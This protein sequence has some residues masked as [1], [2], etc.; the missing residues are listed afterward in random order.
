MMI[1]GKTASEG[2]AVGKAIRLEKETI[3][4]EKQG[5]DSIE[6]CLKAF[7]EALE[8]SREEIKT[9]Q[10]QAEDRLGSEQ[11]EIFGAHLE[12][13]DDPEIRKQVEAM[14]END[15]VT[16]AYAYQTITDQYIQMFEQMEDE[17]FRGRAADIKDIQ[18]RVLA[19]LL[20]KE[21][22]DLSLLEEDTIVVAKDLTPSDTAGLDL[23]K[24]KGF[25]TES[26]GRTSHTAIIA[27]ALGLPAIVGANGALEAIEDNQ[28][29]FLNASDNE[30]VVDPGKKTL[31]RARSLGRE[32]EKERERLKAYADR[33]TKTMNGKGIPLYANIGSDKELD[34]VLENGAEGVGLFRTEFLFMDQPAMPD[35]ERQI[36]AY[37]RVFEKLSPVIVRTLDIGGDKDLPYLEQPKEANPF[38]GRRAIRLT[39]E[40]ESLFQTQ[41]RALLRAARNQRD[42]RIMF[43]MVATEKELDAALEALERARRSLD[44]EGYE[45]QTNIKVGIMIEIPAAALNARRL[46]EKVH[47]FSIGTNDL[48]QYLFAADRMNESV[49]YLYQPLDTTLLRLIKHV[50]DEAHAEQTEVGV[51][52]EIAGDLDAALL[53]A[54]IGVDELSMS[55][56]SI[57]RIREALARI[58]STDLERLSDAVL[59]EHSPQTAKEIVQAFRRKHLEG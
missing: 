27:R 29:V 28:R 26:G 13:L 6:A 30:I 40:E 50:V 17:Y 58:D 55:P 42:V 47:F 53:L 2:Y 21:V 52:G 49:A 37:E 54:G 11:A 4:A 20:G 44:E 12:M 22:K 7:R 8:K 19:H 14:I 15:Q 25:I 16:A 46:A 18:Q 56:A 9:I 34:P 38:L 59:A 24:V 35:E 43:P 33:K 51:C 39:L 48:I 5:C 32:Q 10:K 57:L 41:L 31:E 1:K 3:R 23:D 36:Q 45:Y